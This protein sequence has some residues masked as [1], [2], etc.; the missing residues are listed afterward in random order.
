V[1][2]RLR[3][4][5]IATHPIQYYSPWFRGLAAD[6]AIELKVLYLRKPDARR[7]GEGFG[8]EFQWDV[9]LLA[10]HDGAVLTPEG[11]PA[12]LPI[13][14]MRLWRAL[15]GTRPDV[16]LL[17]GWQEPALIVAAILAR[18]CGARTVVRGESNALRRRP[19]LVRLA[20][21][22]LLRLYDRFIAIGSASRDFYLGYG[23]AAARIDEARYFVENAR[24]EQQAATLLPER[25]KWRAHFG[26]PEAATCFLF[27]GKLIAK[28]DPWTFV[29][30]LEKLLADGLTVHGLIVGDGAMRA[31]LELFCTQHQVPITFAGFL[32]QTEIGRAYAAAD[33][34]VLP[35]DYGETWG[36]VVNEAM[37]FGRPAIVSDR[38]GCGPDLVEPNVTGMRFAFG[39]DVALADRMKVIA[40]DPDGA[41]CMGEAARRRV[42]GGYAPW[43]AVAA[44]VEALR[45]LTGIGKS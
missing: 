18:L 45:A 9:D 21:H 26:C 3:V 32:N 27:A 16:V 7:Q 8:V 17:T 36:L 44:T 13:L 24:F 34:L 30:A 37:L 15:R 2:E 42:E 5:A 31:E 40:A 43:Q 22:L 20:H 6:P 33:T 25:A 11:K 29:S 35:S 12:S 10:G 41:R 38:V 4:V 14:A 19:V 1:A 39:D 23:I 28:K